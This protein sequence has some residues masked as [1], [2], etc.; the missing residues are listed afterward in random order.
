MSH[1]NSTQHPGRIGL[2]APA[3]MA[4]DGKFFVTLTEEVHTVRAGPLVF[5]CPL[6]SEVKGADHR[7]LITP[8]FQYPG[9]QI[10]QHARL[11]VLRAAPLLPAQQR[12]LRDF[13]GQRYDGRAVAFAVKVN[14]HPEPIDQQLIPGRLAIDH[15][16]TPAL[17]P[18]A[19][20]FPRASLEVPHS[21]LPCGWACR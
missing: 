8:L 10:N 9:P 13:D 17:G 20:P 4:D 12:G 19:L 18:V 1:E 3:V 2:D 21:R 5:F 11:L 7:N 6:P 16:A 15:D 14:N